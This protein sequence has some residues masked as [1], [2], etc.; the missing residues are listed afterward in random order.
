MR[1][2]NEVASRLG[3]LILNVF[4]SGSKDNLA[5]FLIEIFSLIIFTT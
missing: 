3:K 5:K 2:I 4:I 1:L